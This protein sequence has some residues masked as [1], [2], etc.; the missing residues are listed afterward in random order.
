MNRKILKPT[1]LFFI[2]AF[3]LFLFPANKPADTEG[4]LKKT[5]IYLNTAYSFEERAADL[6]SRLTLEEKQSLL[7]NNMAAVPRLGI[8]SLN[9]WSEA[10]HGVLTS[11]NQNVGLDGP[12]S[13]PNSVALGSAWDPE[14]MQREAA[15]ISDEGRAIYATGTKG[16][17]FWSP[18][19]EPIRDPRW[20]RTGESFG[21]DPFLVSQIAGGF[22]RGMMGDDP[23]YLKA[24]PTAKHYFANNSEFDRHV[25]SSDMDS[26]DMREFYLSPYK[27][28]IEEDNLP[29]IMTAYNAMNGVPAS[30]STLYLDTIARRTYGMD[31]YI[32]GDCAAIEDIYTGHYYV[33]TAAEATAL[34]LIAGVDSD[35]GSVYQRSAI[36]AINKG[37][38]KMAHID[39]ALVNVFTI[40]MRIGE[41][42][43]VEK[44]PYAQTPAN[45]VNSPANRALALEVATKTPVLLKN[46]VIA[47]TN[48]KALPLVHSD[49]KKIALIGPQIDKVE[50]G[51]YSG[52]P[53]QE[54]MITPLA[55]FNKYISEKGYDIEV[56]SGTGG[57]TTNKSN[58]L[59]VVAI[60][61]QKT[62]GSTKSIDATK[63]SS[64]SEGISVGSGMGSVEQVR[65]INDGSWTA[66]ENVDVTNIDSIRI[67]L[68]IPVDGGLVE[69]RVGSPD[70]NL[71]T[72]LDA[73]VAGGA[74]SGGVYG[75]GSWMKVK[76]NRLGFNEPQ[77]L[78]LVYKAPQDS[79]IDE[80]TIEM[81]KSADVAVLFV[82]TDEKT[83]TEEA[84]RLTLLLPGN[85]VELIKAVAAVNPNTIVYMQTLGCVEV[86][87]FKNLQNILG[88][89]WVGY[90]GQAQGDAVAPILF[91]DVTPGGKLN[92]TWYKT[93][94]DL[95]EITDYTLRGG[96]GK[97]GRTFW[98]FDKDVSYEFGYG[99]SYTTFEYSNFKISKNTITP[100]DKITISVD[101]KNTGQFDGDEVVQVYMKTPDSPASLQRPIK[102]L[103]GFN[104]VTIPVGQTKTVDIDIN[105]ADLWFWD[106][107]EDKI[108]YDQGKYLFEIGTS[109]KEIKGTVSTTMSGNLI[110]ELKTVVADCGT[111]IME[112]GETAQ[113]SLTAAMT[114]DTF[115]DISKAKVVYTSNNDAVIAV[116]ENGL[117]TAKGS[118]VA[119]ITAH[120]T[121]NG[122]TE[123]DGFAIKVMPNL[124]PASIT[125]DSKTVKGFDPAVLGYSYLLKEISNNAPVVE[126]KAVDPK[127][128]VK[129]V[130]AERIPGSA[131]I[132]LIDNSTITSKN[133]AV[134]FG[135]NSV[136]DEFKSTDLG[137]QWSWVRENNENWSLS[138]NSGAMLIKSG[139]GDIAGNENTAENIL[140]QSANTDWTIESKLSVSR[141]PTANQQGGILAYQDD[142]N[143]VKLVF[144]SNPRSFRNT[145]GSAMIDMIV[146]ENGE[147]SSL[148]NM[149]GGGSIAE[150]SLVLKLERKGSKITG[151]Y[152]TDG[153]KF[154]EVASV[155]ISLSNTKA[156]MIVCDGAENS[157]M[158]GFRMPRRQAT[159]EP[160]VQGD[161]EVAYDYFKI[162]NSGLK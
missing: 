115:Y 14:L 113:T 74:R 8:K 68:N 146:E 4:Q 57:E 114:D 160:E 140:L 69:V 26:R 86:E 77:T 53:N 52:R 128:E 9:V 123:S 79:P 55:G 65:T 16:I 60:E 104:R 109:S 148:V 145:G 159:T 19:V 127:V 82:G 111:V 2:G 139:K 81:A 143:Y 17:M 58:L 154:T 42:D 141:M 56:L 54:N 125:V 33:E 116:D 20:G 71:I 136:S 72:T 64:A 18:V 90:N 124:N 27:K 22:V 3:F 67:N 121:I 112:N 138:K 63:Y 46:N 99:L 142:D 87:E 151:S 117:I 43:P 153:R 95:P 134:N 62:D 96:A 120:V 98:Y 85:Q 157:G 70:G 59:Y 149:R 135:V 48:R 147:T 119:T 161:F 32:T 73:T 122:K 44:V 50:L 15:A 88:I 45:I 38:I 91:G 13:F 105:C 6:V 31:G 47:K 97:N 78:F 162:K 150:N 51:P 94:N 131:K 130:Q 89:I 41:F 84:D 137:S 92:A 1:L 7:G 75:G 108:T 49:I 36:E 11:G 106:M 66:Y 102:R 5:P 93:V 158:G 24:V 40:R 133:Y 80:A 21:E 39:R 25:S 152:S 155:D 10:L 12:T 28:L 35:C 83:A 144:K 23:N 37:L 103:K 126:V 61:L 100:Q 156:G 118:G 129:V 101:V 107:E 34:G 110:P 30:A 29:S 132:T 76:A